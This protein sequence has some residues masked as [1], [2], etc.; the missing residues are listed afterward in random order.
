MGPAAAETSPAGSQTGGRLTGDLLTQ[1]VL[2]QLAGTL[3]L[4]PLSLLSLLSMVVLLLLVLLLLLA[5]RQKRLS[6]TAVAVSG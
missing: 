2:V 1:R 4:S 3:C 6:W 5:L